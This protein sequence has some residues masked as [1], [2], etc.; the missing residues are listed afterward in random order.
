MGKNMTDKTRKIAII[1]RG[2]GARTMAI[3][4]QEKLKGV[5]VECI[6][7]DDIPKRRCEPGERMIICDDLVESERKT[8]VSQAVAQLRKA[9]ISYCEAEADYRD[10]IASQ[11]YQKPPRLYG[12]AQHKRQAKKY[13]NRSKR[14]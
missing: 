1:G 6:S 4:L 3:I 14:K 12:A 9:D 2:I 5:E 8:L 13:K 7:V 10:I 11:R